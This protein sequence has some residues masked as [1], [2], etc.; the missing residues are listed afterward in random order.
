M[1]TAYIDTT[2]TAKEG[3]VCLFECEPTVEIEY[4]T[5]RGALT[6]WHIRDFRFD[7]WDWRGSVA[8][9]MEWAKVCEAWCPDYM[10]PILSQFAD[11]TDI[12]EK[13]LDY[14]EHVGEIEYS[15]NRQRADYH[16]AVL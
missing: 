9:G 13:L 3:G 8:G 16:A 14:L 2:I 11:R 10:R 6:D 4:T 1:G 7:C 12:E 5:D 15:G